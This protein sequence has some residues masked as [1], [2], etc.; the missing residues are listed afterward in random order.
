[1]RSRHIVKQLAHLVLLFLDGREQRH[2]ALSD[3]P[4]SSQRMQSEAHLIS[5]KHICRDGMSCRKVV[6]LLISPGLLVAPI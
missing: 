5:E 6:I 2:G 4:Q 1:M 3:P